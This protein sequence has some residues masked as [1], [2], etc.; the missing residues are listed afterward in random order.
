M[1][2][3]VQLGSMT[4]EM[5]DF[6]TACVQA[7]LNIIVWRNWLR[8]NNAVECAGFMYANRAAHRHY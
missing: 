8:Q 7:R 1:M 4:Q 6:L 5:A 3:L 2:D